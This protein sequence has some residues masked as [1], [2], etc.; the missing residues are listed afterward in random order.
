MEETSF[1]ELKTH[2]ALHRDLLEFYEKIRERIQKVGGNTIIALEV[3]RKIKNWFINHFTKDDQLLANITIN[4]AIL[5]KIN[6]CSTLV[7]FLNK[8]INVLLFKTI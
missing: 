4:P 7:L 1:P 6:T 5:K 3:D 2:R 8:A